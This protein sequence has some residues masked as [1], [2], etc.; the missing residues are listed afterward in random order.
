[1]TCVLNAFRSKFPLAILE[2]HVG[3]NRVKSAIRRE[4]PK[5]NRGI[6]AIRKTVAKGNRV[7]FAIRRAMSGVNFVRRRQFT[8]NF[9]SFSPRRRHFCTK[10]VSIRLRAGPH[11]G[12]ITYYKLYIGHLSPVMRDHYLKDRNHIAE[13]IH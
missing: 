5:G 13:L 11:R 1:V 10:L 3:G 6:F 4:P 8:G 9:F 7:N 2:G 12:N